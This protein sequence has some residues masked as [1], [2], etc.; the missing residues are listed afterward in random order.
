MGEREEAGYSNKNF[1]YHDRYRPNG[2]SKKDKDL[3]LTSEDTP[4]VQG[5]LHSTHQSSSYR[6]PSTSS[7]SETGQT[8]SKT[9]WP[10][11]S[12][13]PHIYTATEKTKTTKITPTSTSKEICLGNSCG[14][15]MHFSPYF[16]YQSYSSSRAW[17]PQW[18]KTTKTYLPILWQGTYTQL[19]GVPHIQQLSCCDQSPHLP[20]GTGKSPRLCPSR[21]DRLWHS[22]F[23]HCK[24]LGS[25]NNPNGQNPPKGLR[26]HTWHHNAVGII[27]NVRQLGTKPCEWIQLKWVKQSAASQILPRESFQ[28]IF[29]FFSLYV[30][31]QRVDL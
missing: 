23:A 3:S 21:P 24:Q 13:I 31:L 22:S 6:T 27:W 19:L 10:T 29:W 8:T 20:P 1:Y 11:L 17:Q 5:P 25:D 15:L 26:A 30:K 14:S 16:L 9:V 7:F 12:T 28:S 4:A 2:N 18:H